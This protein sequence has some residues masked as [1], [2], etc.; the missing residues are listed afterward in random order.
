M[1]EPIKAEIKTRLRSV[2]RLET[3]RQ[4]T[5][6][7]SAIKEVLTVWHLIEADSG[8]SL[9]IYSTEDLAWAQ[10]ELIY[11]AYQIDT[12]VVEVDVDADFFGFDKA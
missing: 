3:M 8:H 9:G 5:K 4:I 12:D 2:K 10:S 11:N 1:R 7:N 6:P